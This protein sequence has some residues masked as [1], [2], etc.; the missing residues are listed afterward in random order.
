MRL[1]GFP[2]SH[3]G[4]LGGRDGGIAHGGAVLRR[5]GGGCVGVGVGRLLLLLLGGAL[6]VV[7]QLNLGHGDAFGDGGDLDLQVGNLLSQSPHF[8]FHTFSGLKNM[9]VHFYVFK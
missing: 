8:R 5:G 9:R 1:L 4:P 7:P 2:K 3:A 6:L